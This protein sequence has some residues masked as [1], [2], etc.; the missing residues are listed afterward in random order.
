MQWETDE[1]YL[2]ISIP[3]VYKNYLKPSTFFNFFEKMTGKRKN[4]LLE[5]FYDRLFAFC[6]KVKVGLVYLYTYLE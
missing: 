4:Y 5:F 6:E 3:L 1:K 2:P